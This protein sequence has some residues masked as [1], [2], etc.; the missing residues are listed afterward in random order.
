[1]DA[2]LIEA[3]ERDF[4]ELLRDENESTEWR[5]FG[6]GWEKPLRWILTGYDAIRKAC[7]PSLHV[8]YIKEK[9]GSIDVSDG[10]V[11]SPDFTTDEKSEYILNAIEGI[12]D[13]GC[14][15]TGYICEHCGSFKDDCGDMNESLCDA[16]LAKEAT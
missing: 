8:P 14:M 15:M 9:G 10:P 13:V 2:Q 5:G 1:M 7:I 11:R 6:N 12:G 4:P 3:I 16:C